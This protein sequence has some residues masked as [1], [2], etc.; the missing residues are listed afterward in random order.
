[1]S[2]F[3]V[4]NRDANEGIILEAARAC[5]YV[6]FSSPAIVLRGFYQQGTELDGCDLRF[7]DDLGTFY[8][9][10]KNP[11]VPKYDRELTSR[12]DKLMNL[13]AALGQPFYV[14][15]TPE[16]MVKILNGRAK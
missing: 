6:P 14:V 13:C 15:E 2:K 7:V 3:A 11:D 1:M 8:V 5:G 16:Q 12:E 9:E 10:V 4:G